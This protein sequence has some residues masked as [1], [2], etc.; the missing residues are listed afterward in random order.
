[1]RAYLTEGHDPATALARTNAVL[2]QKDAELFATC[3]LLRL[4]QATGEV[5]VATAGHPAPLVLTGDATVADFDVTPGA[6]RRPH[7]LYRRSAA[8]PVRPCPPV[9]STLGY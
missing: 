4:D 2:L 3:C 6:P 7:R 5:V 8:R 9:C 1:V